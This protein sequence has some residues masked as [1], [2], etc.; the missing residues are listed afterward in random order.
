[1]KKLKPRDGAR[2]GMVVP[3][4]TLFRG[5]AFATVKREL[6]ERFD[7]HTVV[8]LPPGTFAPYSDVKTALIFFDRPGP[9]R[10]AW[11]YELPVPEGLKK[12]SKGSPI[13]DEH[14]DRA[15]EL[16]AAW[17]SYRRGERSRPDSTDDSW[18]VPVDEIRERE[19]DLSARNPNRDEMETYRH[20]AEIT[21]SLLEKERQILSIIEEPH[22]M[23]GDGNDNPV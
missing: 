20:P 1:M 17:D 15:R 21:A 23:V 19:Y 8:S 5:G 18:I 4:G 22:E 9:T 16:W 10:E 13:E 14:F 11:Y 6:L 7:V 3:E 12:F 2:C